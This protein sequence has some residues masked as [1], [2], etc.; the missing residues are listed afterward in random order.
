MWWISNKG[1]HHI[2]CCSGRLPATDSQWQNPSDRP[3]VAD[4]Q[5]CS[6]GLPAADS[7]RRTPSGRL[8]AA[9]SQRQTPS[10]RLPAANSQRQ[11]PSYAPS[12]TISLLETCNIEPAIPNHVCFRSVPRYYGASCI[13]WWYSKAYQS[14]KT[15]KR[16]PQWMVPLPHQRRIESATQPL[17]HRLLVEVYYVNTTCMT[18]I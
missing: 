15:T 3:L 4:S 10:S 9:N 7:Q 14:N 6:G 11:T 17:I 1:P 5:Q 13:W 8:P 16:L 12:L 18:E 2:A